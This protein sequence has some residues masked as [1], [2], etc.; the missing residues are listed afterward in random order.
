MNT[1]IEL[2]SSKVRKLEITARRQVLDVFSGMYASAFKGRGIEVDD[3]REYQIGDDIRSI[4]WKKTAQA[5]RPFVKEFREERNLTVMLVVD[6]SASLAY[7]SH[8]ESK[9]TRLAEVGALLA[10]S[11]IYNHDRVGLVLFSEGIQKEI[12]PRRGL[13]HGARL[14][15]ELIGFTP[16]NPRT[17]LAA[18][19]DAFNMAAKKRCICFLLSDFLS[20]GYEKQFGYTA[21]KEDLVAIRLFDPFESS[22][23]KLNLCQ[24][25]DLESGY[26][27]LVDVNADVQQ[28]VAISASEREAA[29]DALAMKYRAGALSIDTKNSFVERLGAYFKMRKERRQ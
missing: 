14:I 13:R 8:F 20:E 28:Q 2:L 24:M 4:S 25:Q 7:G 27:F 22:I 15:R 12:A 23:P 21:K 19:L 6:V 11:A 29:F 3:V 18:T 10:F 16:Q 5:G 26:S 1:E 17:S 9:R